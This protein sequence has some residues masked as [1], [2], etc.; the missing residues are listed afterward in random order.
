MKLG[1]GLWETAQF[2]ELQQL[3]QVGLGTTQTNNDRFKI[4]YSYGELNT[5]GTVDAAKNIGNIA[6][7]TTTIPSLS[8]V[9]TF[10]YDSINR[11]SE[12]LH[13]QIHWLRLPVMPRRSKPL[14]LLQELPKS[15]L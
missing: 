1:N 9:Q 4:E 15:A 12:A 10:K 14:K 5:D 11:L 3:T 6:K 8:F 13:G 2:N 7:T